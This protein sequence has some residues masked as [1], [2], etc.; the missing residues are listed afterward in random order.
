[1]TET[2]RP[3]SMIRAATMD[4]SRA[5]LAGCLPCACDNTTVRR[6]RAIS[7]Q[8]QKCNVR[9]QI[10][11]NL[12]VADLVQAAIRN[13]KSEILTYGPLTFVVYFPSRRPETDN[14]LSG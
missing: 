2:S 1:M 10:W 6:W 11:R 9:E 13:P 4:S 5:R 8:F 14:T 3:D 7:P 12:S